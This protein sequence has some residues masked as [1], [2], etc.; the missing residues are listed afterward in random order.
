VTA[1]QPLHNINLVSDHRSA[2]FLPR[3]AYL[4]FFV[5]SLGTR[6]H[7]HHRS[8]SN[9]ACML[10]QGEMG[11]H[12]SHSVEVRSV[13]LQFVTRSCL[14]SPSIGVTKSRSYRCYGTATRRDCASRNVAVVNY[15]TSSSSCLVLLSQFPA[16]L[17]KGCLALPISLH[18]EL[19]ISNDH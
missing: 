9:F 5:P 8:H 16:K 10:S 13:T 6:K 11:E 14:V 17:A 1:T 18:F 15:C 19:S 12:G 7:M 2:R 4:F 3:F